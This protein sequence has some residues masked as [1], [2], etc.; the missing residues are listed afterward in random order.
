[1]TQPSSETWVYVV[2]IAAC[3]AI[4]AAWVFVPL[5]NDEHR[6]RNW[7]DEQYEELRAKVLAKLNKEA[8]HTHNMSRK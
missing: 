4:I 6:R 1:V 8:D 3:V 7:S 2:G 5:H